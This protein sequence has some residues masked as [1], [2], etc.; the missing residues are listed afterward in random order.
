[1]GKWWTNYPISMSSATDLYNALNGA[2]PQNRVVF[3]PSL[4]AQRISGTSAYELKLSA[5]RQWTAQYMS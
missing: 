5:V 2:T 3:K 4:Y 1:M